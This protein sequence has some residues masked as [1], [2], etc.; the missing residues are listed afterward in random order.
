MASLNTTSYY[1]GYDDGLGV[2]ATFVNHACVDPALGESDLVA[3]T[4][5][6]TALE[7][8]FDLSNNEDDEDLYF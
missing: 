5:Q 2:I 1:S 4:E 6:F 8:E 3:T 7:N